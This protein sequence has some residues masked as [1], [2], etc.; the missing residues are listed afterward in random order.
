MSVLEFVK[1]CEFGDDLP[2]EEAFYPSMEDAIH[3]IDLFRGS[4]SENSQ[5]EAPSLGK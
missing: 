4:A 3:A 1:R 2:L 5:P